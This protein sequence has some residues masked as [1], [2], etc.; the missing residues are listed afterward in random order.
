MGK[1]YNSVKIL[2]DE[3]EEYYD[4]LVKDIEY[5]FNIKEYGEE[6]LIREIPFRNDILFVFNLFPYARMEL[7][8]CQYAD[9][10]TCVNKELQ[11]RHHEKISVKIGPN[12]YNFSLALKIRYYK[13]KFSRRRP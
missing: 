10:Q 2:F 9:L 7:D 8:Y 5:F 13:K 11:N 12:S 6:N 3:S 1:T 4:L